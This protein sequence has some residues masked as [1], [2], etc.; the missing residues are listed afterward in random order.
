MC[1]EL[2]KKF[3]E[4]FQ[5]KDSIVILKE[6]PSMITINVRGVNSYYSQRNNIVRP[7]IACNVTAMVAAL[8]YA[9]YTHPVDSQ[10][11]QPEDSLMNFLLNS[12]EVDM[13]Y[14]RLFPDEYK[15]YMASGKDPKKSYPP[16][17]LHALLSLGTNLWMGAQRNAIT[18]FR[19]DLS[20]RDIVY[21]FLNGRPVV[22]SGVFAGLHHVVCLVGIDTH[23][24]D[25]K[26]VTSPD[27]I[28]LDMIQSIIMQ[29]SYG[30]YH[31][32]YKVQNGKDVKMTVPEFTALINVQGQP[33]KWGH[34][35]IK[36]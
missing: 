9:G 29:D 26:K 36:A 14:Q 24:A 3:A 11:A 6:E 20:F 8:E 12:T 17:E 25:I 21:E 23:Q 18:R 1:V 16:S 4:F 22:T 30:D 34:L 33:N 35:F 5:K 32:G 15:K 19:W 31:T 27:G 28:Q 2:F 10:Y 13:A 7:L